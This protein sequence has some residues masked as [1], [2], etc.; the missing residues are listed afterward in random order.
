MT[1]RSIT[2]FIFY[3]VFVS[4]LLTSA[5]S[6][7]W[8]V[9]EHSELAE[10]GLFDGDRFAVKAGSG[11][12]YL[13]RLYGV[14]CPEIDKDN[15]AALKEQGK[16]F[17]KDESELVT[18]G[19]EASRFVRE[20][21]HKPFIVFTQ[22]IKASGSGSKSCYYAIII[23][24]DGQRLDEALVEAGLARS[25]GRGAGWDEPFWGRIQADL[26]RRISAERFVRKLHTLQSKARRARIGVWQK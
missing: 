21:L 2:R 19:E 6:K 26:P 15:K 22:K 11:Y 13:F 7:Q 9:Y 20:F 8:Y 17:D 18:W 25:Y 12:T 5:Q 24:A 1:F 3:L 16:K 23:N 10:E 4:A 14:D